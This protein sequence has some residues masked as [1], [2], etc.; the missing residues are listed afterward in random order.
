M[1]SGGRDSRDKTTPDEP[2]LPFSFSSRTARIRRRATYGD[3]QVSCVCAHVLASLIA[4]FRGVFFFL[5][6]TCF[7][8]T[9]MDLCKNTPYPRHS[10][11]NSPTRIAK[12]PRHTVM[13]ARTQVEELVAVYVHF[14]FIWTLLST[15]Q[16]ISG[17]LRFAFR[18][19]ERCEAWKHAPASS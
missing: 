14:H 16:R 9:R 3:I 8:L 10:F 17:I 1:V 6:P 18:G 5:G 4:S 2:E 12:A 11:C 7:F 13:W 19:T 15:M